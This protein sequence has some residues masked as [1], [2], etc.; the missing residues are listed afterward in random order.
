MMHGQKNIKLWNVAIWNIKHPIFV[1]PLWR[2]FGLSLYIN[3]DI[4][5]KYI[6]TL[7]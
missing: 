3:N 4:P 7:Q 1:L 5:V 6:T 2:G